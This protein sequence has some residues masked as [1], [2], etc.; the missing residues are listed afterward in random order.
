M[1]TIADIEALLSGA[2]FT[3]MQ[4]EAVECRKALQF[5]TVLTEFQERPS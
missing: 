2:G 3:I 1:P 4:T 5:Q